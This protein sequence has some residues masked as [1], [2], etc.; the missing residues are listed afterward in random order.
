MLGA[1]IFGASECVICCIKATRNVKNK[2]SS[3]KRKQQK[4]IFFIAHYTLLST[5]IYPL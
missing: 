5:W 3:S 2:C 1:R 4:R